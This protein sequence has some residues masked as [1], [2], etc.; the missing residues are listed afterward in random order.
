MK[1]FFAACMA[2][3]ASDEGLRGPYKRDLICISRSLIKSI[4]F[5][6]LIPNLFWEISN[7]PIIHCHMLAIK[8][9]G[10]TLIEV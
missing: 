5:A 4:C 10:Q 9:F 2:T 8:L 1:A 7:L 6:S 3:M